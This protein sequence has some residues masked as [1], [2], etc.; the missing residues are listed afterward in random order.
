[1]SVSICLT[2]PSAE[3]AY[4]VVRG[5][6]KAIPSLFRDMVLRGIIVGLGV[7]A[8]GGSWRDAAKFGAAGSVAIQSYVLY[9]AYKK[10]R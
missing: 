2:L 8:A 10:S 5:D 9:F 4:R 7:K 3:T 1:M 6:E